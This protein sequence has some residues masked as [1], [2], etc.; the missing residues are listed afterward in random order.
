M[1]LVQASSADSDLEIVVTDR[2]GNSYME[3]VERPKTF[4][5]DAYVY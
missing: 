3:T 4:S 5:I 1:F 2:Y